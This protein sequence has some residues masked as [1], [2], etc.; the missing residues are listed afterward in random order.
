MSS[1]QNPIDYKRLQVLISILEDLND[2]E[3][4]ASYSSLC[5]DL[6]VNFGVRVSVEQIIE[7]Y[8]PTVEELK[9]DLEIQYRNV[10]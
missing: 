2:K 10:F 9:E 6:L 4:S 1:L 7:Y 8:E 5:K 3:N